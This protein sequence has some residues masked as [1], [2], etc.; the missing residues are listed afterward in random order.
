VLRP[1]LGV[2]RQARGLGSHTF[3][4]CYPALAAVPCGENRY[5]DEEIAEATVGSLDTLKT[6]VANEPT[7][8]NNGRYILPIVVAQHR[9]GPL[10]VLDFSGGPCV[11]LRLIADH[12]HRFDL[13]GFTY[14][15]V[16]TPALCRAIK[17][18]ITPV[19][20]ARFGEASFVTIVEDIPAAIAGPV[21]VNASSAIQYISDYRATIARLAALAPI[22]FIVSLTPFTGGPTYARQQLNIP[23][24]KIATWVF[25]RAEFISEMAGLGY[26]LSF[27]VD[28]ELPITY[29]NAPG[30]S[31]FA[32]MI[33]HSRHQP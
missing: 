1:T 2:W 12:V 4:G 17:R 11:G 9:G 30:A 32:S 16:E 20:L 27:T 3:E 18:R 23:R 21:L 6:F 29:G 22:C 13:S 26:S 15:L 25:N 14:C 28:H 8:D 5:D 10:T 33:F 24:K 31:S 19:L 7:S